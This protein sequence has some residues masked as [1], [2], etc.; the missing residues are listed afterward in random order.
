MFLLTGASGKLGQM[1]LK[2]FMQE[3]GGF[4]KS[5]QQGSEEACEIIAG[6]RDVE[7][8]H[9]I[10]C[11]LRPFDY[12]D[13]DTMASSLKGVHTLLFIS[14]NAEAHTRIAEQRHVIDACMI[15]GVKRVVYLSFVTAIEDASHFSFTFSH[16]DTEAYIRQTPLSYCMLRANWYMENLDPLLEEALKDGVMIDASGSG[17]IGFVSKEDVA[18]AM[19]AAALTPGISNHIFNITGAHAIS[20]PEVASLV[21]KELG[22]KV[23][24]EA[25]SVYDM[26]ER[27]I[28]AGLPRYLANSLAEN[29]IGIDRGEY[30]VVSDDFELLVRK[31]PLAIEDYI[32]TRLKELASGA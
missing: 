4:E 1:V 14:S 18:A 13:I 21:S 15:S 31:R 6:V 22:K 2:R 23:I 12:A 7:G 11:P 19:V 29:A 16:I 27:Y 9:G 30:Q 26:S 17:R 24:Y 25:I 3:I 8:Y 32:A 10:P 5:M 28:A 20:M